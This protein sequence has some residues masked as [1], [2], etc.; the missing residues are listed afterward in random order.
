MNKLLENYAKVIIRSGVNIQK[1]QNLHIKTRIAGIELARLLTKE[2]YDAGARYVKVSIVD[3]EINKL[4][5]IH[6]SEDALINVPLYRVEEQKWLVENNAAHISI[7]DYNPDGMKGIDPNRIQKA[8]RAFYKAI[9][10]DFSSHYMLN[11]SQWCVVA[12]PSVEWANLI[13]PNDPKA[14]EKLLN[15]ILKASYIDDSE[16]PLEKWQKHS[17]EI[18]D[19]CKILNEFNFKYLKYKNSVGTDLTIELPIG[20][21]WCGGSEFTNNEKHIEFNANIPTEEVFTAPKRNG[22][23][24]IVYASKPLIYQGNLIN[25]FYIEFKD[26]RVVNYDAKVGK[27]FLDAL[28]TTDEGSHYLGEVALVPYHSPISMSNILFYETLFDE[29]ASC[30]LALGQAYATTVKNTEGKTVEELL[31][32]GINDSIEHC[33]FMIGTSDLEIIGITQNNKE[34]PVFKNGDFVI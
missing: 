3:D 31:E 24:G 6:M 23:N 8:Q 32:M 15:E 25:D 27:E 26:G 30:H 29:N 10:K 34:I 11:K 33:D 22:V 19:H 12:Y 17:Q 7:V 14:E 28:I 16:K 2:A 20:H 5:F 21:I 13:F 4:G 1:D 18:Q 9:G